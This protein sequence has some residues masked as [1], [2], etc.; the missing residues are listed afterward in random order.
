M[1]TLKALKELCLLNIK[2]MNLIESKRTRRRKRK[3]RKRKEVKHNKW[4]IK[5]IVR[6]GDVNV[7]SKQRRKRSQ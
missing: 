4:S 6:R 7:W 1:I 2:G 5:L 3:G